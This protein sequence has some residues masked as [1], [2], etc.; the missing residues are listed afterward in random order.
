MGYTILLLEKYAAAQSF[1]GPPLSSKAF[2]RKELQGENMST[3]VT[4]DSNVWEIIVDERKR[5]V[6]LP[7]H[8]AD[9]V[10][11]HFQKKRDAKGN[12]EELS[13]EVEEIQ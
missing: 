11:E 10:A 5:A 4:F 12:K 2:M 6:I 3:S 1:G 9:I 13:Y 8:I 7:Y